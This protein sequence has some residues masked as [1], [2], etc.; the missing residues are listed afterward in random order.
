MTLLFFHGSILETGRAEFSPT[1]PS[2]GLPQE[3]VGA[4]TKPVSLP[5]SSNTANDLV[6]RQSI[7]TTPSTSNI[8]EPCSDIALT[9]LSS[10][11]LAAESVAELRAAGANEGPIDKND[12]ATAASEQEAW[13]DSLVPWPASLPPRRALTQARSMAEQRCAR[14]YPNGAADRSSTSGQARCQVYYM[15]VHKSG[16]ST[17]CSLAAANGLNVDLASNCQEMMKSDGSPSS[18]LKRMPWWL[19]PA[20]AQAE[21]FRKSKHDFIS[22]EDNPFTTPPL[23]GPIIFVITVRRCSCSAFLNRTFFFKD[24]N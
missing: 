9:L 18:E 19:Q 1:T 3:R 4:W 2:P 22:N 20:Y 8:E 5:L 21:V 14:N 16:G 7:S 15:H 11:T 6:R 23:P 12:T 10:V 17:L 13:V 24:I